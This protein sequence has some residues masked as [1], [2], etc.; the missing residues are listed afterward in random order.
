MFINCTWLPNC[1]KILEWSIS[2]VLKQ[3]GSVFF[4]KYS[5]RQVYIKQ[6]YVYEWIFTT[7]HVQCYFSKPAIDLQSGLHELESY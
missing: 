7:V 1:V 2:V 5:S 4:P 3:S 6:I